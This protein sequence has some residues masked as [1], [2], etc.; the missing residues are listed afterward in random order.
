MVQPIEMHL[1]T[2]APALLFGLIGGLL[3]AVFTRLNTFICHRRKLLLAKIP[4]RLL[5]RLAKILEPVLLV[6][7]AGM[8]LFAGNTV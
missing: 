1:A 3:A 7:R 5:Q 8:V 4:Y 2:L 6:V